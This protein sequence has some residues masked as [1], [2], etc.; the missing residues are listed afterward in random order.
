MTYLKLALAL[1]GIVRA[2]LSYLEQRK[3]EDAAEAK[4][5]REALDD[6][7]DRMAKVRAAS[8]AAR[9]GGVPGVADDDIFRD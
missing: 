4:L 2:I 5:L 8:D 3:A 1:L 7:T 6:A 9:A